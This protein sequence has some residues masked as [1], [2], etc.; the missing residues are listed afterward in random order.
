MSP[1]E[2]ID[3][4]D[5]TRQEIADWLKARNI[6]PYRAVQVMKWIYIRQVDAFEQMTDLGKDLRGLL[7]GHFAIGRLDRLRTEVSRDGSRKV[8]FGLADGNRIE[9]VLIPERDHTTLCIS[10]QVG[11]AQGCRFCLTARMGFVRNLTAGEIIAQVRD[12]ALDV[13]KDVPLTNIV[14]MGMGEPLAN[15]R[16]VVRAIEILTDS[17]QGL[18]FAGRRVTL[19]TAG[20]VPKMASL[21]RDTRVNLAVSLNASDNAT[22][23]RLMPINRTY[24][25]EVL[26]GACRNYPLGSGRR[27]TFEYILLQGVNDS[28]AD[29][30][31][32]AG[33]LRGLRAKVNLIPFN[34][35]EG[36]GFSRPD[37]EAI[38]RFQEILLGHH[39]TAVIRWSKGQDISAACGQL[40]GSCN[41][42]EP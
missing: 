26:L 28:P 36:S 21:G 3:I 5:R 32:L 34:E 30:H 14:F 12:A 6:A 38:H 9:S 15:Y 41:G 13:S 19:S 4:K 2:K 42:G 33:H 22:R 25:I 29:A 10:S 16:Q 31:R 7:A 1:S 23:D 8:L 17:D 18:K 39:F 37:A 11:C 40:S 24:P 20:L 35:F 27:I